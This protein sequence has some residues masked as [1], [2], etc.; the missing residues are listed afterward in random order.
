M[1]AAGIAVPKMKAENWAPMLNKAS[2]NTNPKA[3]L[4]L[5]VVV[6]HHPKLRQGALHVYNRIRKRVNSFRSFYRLAETP[7]AMEEAGDNE[8]NWEKV[9]RFF[10]QEVPENVSLWSLAIIQR[11]GARLSP[12]LTPSNRLKCAYPDFCAGLCKAPRSTRPGISCD[13]AYALRVRVSVAI[14]ELQYVRPRQPKR[15]ATQ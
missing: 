13:Q 9:N 3:A 11:M 12:L 1:V 10:S 8:R 15:Y 7:F 5:N 4:T 2:F 6:F 14:R